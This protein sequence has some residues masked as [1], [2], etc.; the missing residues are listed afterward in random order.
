MKKITKTAV[1]TLAAGIVLAGQ[2]WA[3]PPWAFDGEGGGMHSGC[4]KGKRGGGHRIFRGLDLTRE[5]K[6]NIKEIMESYRYKIKKAAD[7]LQEA[8][9]NLMKVT[10]SD[11]FNELAIRKACKTV[12]LYTEELAIIR[13]K[14]LAEAKSVLTA[15][16]KHRLAER[17]DRFRKQKMHKQH[18]RRD[19]INPWTEDHPEN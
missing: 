16:Q 6:D 9:R 5:Q 19:N 11:T 12:A 4:H 3:Q 18:E 13:A 17:R 8:R 2:V 10:H 1:L 7:P 15:E 14:A